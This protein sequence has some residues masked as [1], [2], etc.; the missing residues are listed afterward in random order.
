[1]CRHGYRRW[2]WHHLQRNMRPRVAL[3]NAADS[4]AKPS[5][6]TEITPL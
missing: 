4:L 5:V 1:V 6:L 2:L 3:I